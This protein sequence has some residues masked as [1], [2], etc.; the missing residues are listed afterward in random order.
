MYRFRP[1]A[2]LLIAG[3]TSMQ[4][5]KVTDDFP[6][7]LVENFCVPDAE[8]KAGLMEVV[9]ENRQR[10]RR[11]EAGFNFLIDRDYRHFF[12]ILYNKFLK[13]AFEIF[14]GIR[15]L[16]T[17][18]ANVWS[19]VSNGDDH[20]PDD[21]FHNHLRSATI[22][23]VYYLNVP[24]SATLENGSISFL[25]RDNTFAYKPNNFDLLLFPSYLD[26]KISYLDD[27][28]YRVSIN[29]E[30]LCDKVPMDGWQA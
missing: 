9:L 1:S 30:I 13:C 4:Y 18:S 16:P 17:N 19:Y 11:M 23:A 26:H 22:N 5:R 12:A 21:F 8:L 24:S 27:S 28:D 25:L 20:A 6:I 3:V 29:M 14:P 10:N 15:L 2:A 7:L